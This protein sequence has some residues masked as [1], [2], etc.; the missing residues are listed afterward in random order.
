MKINFNFGLFRVSFSNPHKL[1]TLG[2]KPSWYTHHDL[3]IAKLLNMKIVLIENET[4]ALLYESKN[5]I[6]GN[7]C[8]ENVIDY[9]D[10]LEK[11]KNTSKYMK[12]IRTNLFGVTTSKNKKY[13]IVKHDEQ[14]ECSDF[15]L[16]S[17]VDSEKINYDSDYR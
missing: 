2:L 10:K 6:R 15:L 8:F 17:I 9:I 11:N 4:N 5:C 12:A 1:W 13:H 16:E 14:L 7:K 3:N